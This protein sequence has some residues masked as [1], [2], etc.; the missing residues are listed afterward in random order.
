MTRAGRINQPLNIDYNKLNLL[1]RFLCE[2]VYYVS[3]NQNSRRTLFVHVPPL[4]KPFSDRQLARALE[5]I[6]KCALELIGDAPLPADT[7]RIYKNGRAAAT[8]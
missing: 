7:V 1:F 3:L 4:N 8:F 6:V 5:E 2:F